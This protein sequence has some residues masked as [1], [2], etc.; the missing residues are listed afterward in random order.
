MTRAT[1]VML[2]QYETQIKSLKDNYAILRR[3]LASLDKGS[4]CYE[5]NAINIL[6]RM[7]ETRDE[8]RTMENIVLGIEAANSVLVRQDDGEK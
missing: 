6:M 7:K 4:I 5:T 1:K 8:Y 3:D 2:E